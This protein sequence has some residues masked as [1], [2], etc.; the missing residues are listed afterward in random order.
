M[1]ST[2]LAETDCRNGKTNFRLLFLFF[3]KGKF[4]KFCPILPLRMVD[5]LYQLSFCV[6]LHFLRRNHLTMIQHH[7]PFF[8]SHQPIQRLKLI[9]IA[10]S[11]NKQTAIIDMIWT[12]S[13]SLHVCSFF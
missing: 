5:R 6:Q 13:V 4:F 7:E 10:I 9:E 8:P 2:S 3:P 12:Y 1:N 11:Y